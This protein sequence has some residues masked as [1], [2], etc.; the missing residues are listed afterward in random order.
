MNENFIWPCLQTASEVAQILETLEQSLAS[1]EDNLVELRLTVLSVR[2]T[3]VPFLQ[4]HVHEAAFDVCVQGIRDSV[5][6]V[7]KLLEQV[8]GSLRKQSEED[9]FRTKIALFKLDFEITQKVAQFSTLFPQ[10]GP[11]LGAEIIKDPKA[12]H[13]WKQAFGE[14][15]LM[16][17]WATFLHALESKLDSSFQDSEA[18]LRHFLD[19]THDGFVS[20]FELNIFLCWFGPFKGCVKRLIQPLRQGL[21]GGNIPAIEANHLLEGKPAGTYL[22]RFSKTHQGSFAVTF[23]DGKGNTKHCLLYSVQPVGLT[24]KNPPETYSSLMQFAA[25]HTNKLKIPLGTCWSA[26]QNGSK[27]AVQTSSPGS[28]SPAVARQKKHL[29]LPSSPAEQESDLCTVCMDNTIDTVFLECGHL[30]CCKSCAKQLQNKE[31][32]ICREPILRVVAIYRP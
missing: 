6:E 23:V 22:I 13:F 3:L 18:E 27:K 31:C 4:A 7:R 21:L 5:E 30:A 20:P 12:K 11:P 29:A 32:P 26:Q 28:S 8:G 1:E 25:A 2:S 16:V 17:P 19:F 14:K 9:W 15:Y 10:E 24:L